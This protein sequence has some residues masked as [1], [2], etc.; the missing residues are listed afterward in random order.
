M[1]DFL[2]KYEIPERI[3]IGNRYIS[4]SDPVFVI[5]EIGNNHNGDYYLAKRTIE[6]ALK[7]GADAIKLQKRSV[8][9][10]FAKELL[11]REQ[12]KD[13]I[14]GK[15]Y[16]EY[17]KHLELDEDAYRKLK[18]MTEA[19]G[20]I[21]FATPFDFK[22]ADF[23]ENLGV[24][25]YKIASFDSTN[26]PLLEHVARK[27]KPMIVSL[28][29]CTLDEADEAVDTVLRHNP[30]LILLHCV[31]V[32]PTTDEH[33]RLRTVP[34]IK[35]RYNLP[36]GY[37]GHEPDILPTL[38]AVA[39]GART[40]ERHITIDKAL[41]GPDHG[42][43]SIAPG[44]FKTMVDSIRRLEI[45]L[46]KYEKVLLPEEQRARDKHSKSLVT[47]MAIPSGTVLTA[48]MIT[49]KS[50]GYGLKPRM[51][52]AVLGKKTLADIPEDTVITNEFIQWS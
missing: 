11:D 48:N 1:P 30:N 39:M 4:H 7:A 32:Y 6:E 43:V 22:S 20:A 26:L 46:G 19:A 28:G 3:R 42:T 41:P 45:A 8:D 16:G 34:F 37:S 12:T 21:F 17:R 36:T 9:D 25:L 15:T 18:A 10:V 49:C 5:A 27:G 44:E 33:L 24:E 2:K 47:T 31:S 14:F 13:Q 38:A 40:V 35:D 52:P 51:L 23:L 50:P 29:M